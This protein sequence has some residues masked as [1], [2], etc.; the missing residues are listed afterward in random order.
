MKDLLADVL[1]KTRIQILKNLTVQVSWN[2]I[3][4]THIQIL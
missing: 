4:K 1:W 2:S 3:W